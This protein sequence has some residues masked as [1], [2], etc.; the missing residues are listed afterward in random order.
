MNLKVFPILNF[1]INSSNLLAFPIPLLKYPRYA[2]HLP[3]FF[4]P[5]LATLVPLAFQILIS[6]RAKTSDLA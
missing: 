1:E 6:S 4:V 3:S 2:A 5:L